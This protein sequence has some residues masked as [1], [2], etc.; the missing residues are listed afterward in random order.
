MRAG[1]AAKYVGLAALRS[2]VSFSEHGLGRPVA[3]SGVLSPPV[4]SSS[5]VAVACPRPVLDYD[6]SWEFAG[7]EHL[8]R[9]PPP[10][11]VIPAAVFGPV[12]SLAEATAATCDLKDALEQYDLPPFFL[13][14]FFL[15]KIFP[16]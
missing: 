3:V 2:P 8:I 16:R 12:P 14:F 9:D 4:H 10:T 7:D 5:S 1:L 13:S 6:D 15:K 11:P